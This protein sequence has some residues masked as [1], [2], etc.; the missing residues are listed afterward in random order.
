MESSILEGQILYS[1]IHPHQKL[2]LLPLKIF[3]CVRFAYDN[4]IDMTNSDP[5]CVFFEYS[6]TRK[7][8][9]ISINKFMTSVDATF[10]ESKCYFE[11]DLLW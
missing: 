1:L 6:N 3:G 4:P 10:F 9:N 11:F 5:N 2:F 7:D 8:I